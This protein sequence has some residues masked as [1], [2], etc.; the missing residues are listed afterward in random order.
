[1]QHLRLSF[2]LYTRRNT[3]TYALRYIYIYGY[4]QDIILHYIH[5]FISIIRLYKT[6]MWLGK[7][8]VA[9]VV[10][11]LSFPKAFSLYIQ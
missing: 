3:C 9:V 5:I 6:Q 7:N 1:M 2:F 8:G 10:V 11:V 4:L